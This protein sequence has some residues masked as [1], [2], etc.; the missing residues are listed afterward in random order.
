MRTE[1]KIGTQKRRDLGEPETEWSNDTD[2][3]WDSLRKAVT[4]RNSIYMLF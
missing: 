2:T 3:I 1:A 4:I